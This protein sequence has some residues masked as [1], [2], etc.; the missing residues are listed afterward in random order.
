MSI[1]VR[2][3][4]RKK[5]HR[6]LYRGRCRSTACGL[7][8]DKHNVA[9]EGIGFL[10]VQDLCKRCDPWEKKREQRRLRKSKQP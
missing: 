1:M 5:W 6:T 9:G 3:S 4:G 10:P 7:S 8:L 2:F